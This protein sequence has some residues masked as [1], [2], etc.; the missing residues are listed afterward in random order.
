[1]SRRRAILRWAG[2]ALLAIAAALGPLERAAAGH[3]LDLTTARVTHRDGH[4][5]V[6]VEVDVL[7][8]VTQEV[9]EAKDA[10]TI[11]TADERTLATFVAGARSAMEGGGSLEADGASV[12]LVLR[13]FPTSSEMRFA[14]AEASA[15]PDHH[16]AVSTVRF[17]TTAPL[18]H[19]RRIAV[20]LPSSLGR[21]LY[22]Y[23]QPETHLSESGAPASFAVLAPARESATEATPP[24]TSRTWLALGAGLLGIA[25]LALQWGR[26]P[27]RT[28]RET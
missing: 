17:E 20:K 10:T 26:R 14:A 6:L 9:A 21:I 28:A 12:P 27:T 18:G 13:T 16:P 3:A 22:T 24:P 23:V 25:A 4:V 5:E 7:R 15:S 11:A 2:T 1:M 8:L 19:P